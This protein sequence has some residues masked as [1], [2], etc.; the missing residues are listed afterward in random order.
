ML[1]QRATLAEWAPGG[2][3][4]S[5]VRDHRQVKI[6]YPVTVI[7]NDPAVTDRIAEW[8]WQD[9]LKPTHDA[10]VWRMDSFRDRFL[11]AFAR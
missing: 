9:S 11:S 1:R 8:G 3:D 10:P 6:V 7:A 5:P 2:T 4:G